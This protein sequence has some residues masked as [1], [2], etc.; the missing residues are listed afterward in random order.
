MV[1]VFFRFD[2]ESPNFFSA[3][4]KSCIMDF[5]LERQKYTD[6]ASLPFAVGIN[7]MLAEELYSA[8]YPLHD[9]S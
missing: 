7:R 2:S 6:D 8:A 5:I 4:I 1:C 9:V 3:S